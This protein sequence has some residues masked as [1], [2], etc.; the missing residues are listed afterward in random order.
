MN[1]ARVLFPYFGSG[2]TSRFGGT[3]LL[4]ILFPLQV[5]R[6]FSSALLLDFLGLAFLGTV[7][8]AALHTSL[9]V[10]NHPGVPDFQG[11]TAS[12]DPAALR[13]GEA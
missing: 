9:E 12:R 4:G 11:L 7:L 10:G 1:L 13:R 8:R 3:L 6:T 2:S 5:I